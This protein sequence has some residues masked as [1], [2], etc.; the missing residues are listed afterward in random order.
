MR[1]F[2][3]SVLLAIV[4]GS[5]LAQ[6]KV[7]NVLL[8][9][10]FA[11]AKA[12]L[13]DEAALW[14]NP[15]LRR[16]VPDEQAEHLTLEAAVGLWAACPDQELPDHFLTER[17]RIAFVAGDFEKAEA[18]ARGLLQDALKVPTWQGQGRYVYYGNEVLGRV[19]L[20]KGDVANA[21]E[22]LLASGQS[23][24][25]PVLK[26][27]G[28]NLLLAKE[29]LQIGERDTVLKFLDECKEGFWKFRA[30]Q[31]QTWQDA[32]QQGKTPS[33]GFNLYLYW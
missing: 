8:A 5:T 21:K 4:G 2:T 16:C 19:S 32:I 14:A 23:A 9:R 3:V 25:D 30:P 11:A 15:R 12:G 1:L 10:S 29:L 18:Y 7:D 20:R 22:F 27:F 24:G 28:P 6:S 13:Y 31:I 26:S 17:A 33:F